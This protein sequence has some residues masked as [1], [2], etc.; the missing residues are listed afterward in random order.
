MLQA[1]SLNRILFGDY[2]PPP[3]LNVRRHSIMDEAEPKRVVAP[4]LRKVRDHSKNKARLAAQGEASRQ[5]VLQTISKFPGSNA[6]ELMGL[7]GFSRSTIGKTI[8]AL[9]ASNAIYH[10]KFLLSQGGGYT[11]RHY[12]VK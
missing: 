4:K 5:L 11:N 3:V 10:Q 2:V 7:T 8:R 1:V 6:E 12:P 9:T